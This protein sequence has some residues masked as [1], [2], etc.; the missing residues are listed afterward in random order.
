M[1]QV[2]SACSVE[3]E[4][5]TIE[6]TMLFHRL[7]LVAERNNSLQECFQHE[8][9]PYPMSLFKDGLMQKPVKADLYRGFASGLTEAH[10]PEVVHYV[11]KEDLLFTRLHNLQGR[12][13]PEMDLCDILPLFL[14]FVSKF[15]REVDVVFDS[16]AR[17]QALKTINMSDVLVKLHML[18]PRDKSISIPRMLDKKNRSWLTLQTRKLSLMC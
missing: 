18:A 4:K 11:S 10:L 9:T 2:M 5:V 17:D 16:Y 7:I 13:H 15:D 14:T 3:T 6:P 8:L 12:W 1:S